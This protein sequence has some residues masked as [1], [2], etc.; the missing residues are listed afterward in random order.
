MTEI[1]WLACTDPK[2]IL[3]LLWGAVDDRKLRLIGV[4]CIQS[5]PEYIDARSGTWQ[6]DASEYR[7]CYKRGPIWYNSILEA[8]VREWHHVVDTF[9]YKPPGLPPTPFYLKSMAALVK[10]VEVAEL[11]ADGQATV[12]EL[13][14]AHDAAKEVLTYVDD[15]AAND[16]EMALGLAATDVS[17]RSAYK[18][19]LAARTGLFHVVKDLETAGNLKSQCDI[20]RDVIGNPFRPTPAITSAM[21]SWDNDRIRKLAQVIYDERSFDRLP[22]LADTLEAAG[23]TNPDILVHCREPGGHWRGCWVV[24][25]LL[26]MN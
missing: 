20:L 26:G 14:A 8:G 21:L 4:A 12:Q 1:E 19:T 25:S 24:D 13:S 6:G 9:M 22:I 15:H 2:D 23:C 3:E 5:L 10:A 17:H 16:G 18:A 7:R 11:F